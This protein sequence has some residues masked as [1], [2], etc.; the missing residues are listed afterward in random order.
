MAFTTVTLNPG[1]GGANVAFWQDGVNAV[2]QYVAIES[3]VPGNDPQ[4][5]GS[6]NPLPVTF[7]S[8]QPVVGN[9]ASGASD[10]GNGVK[11]A[12]VYNSTPSTFVN[13]QRTDLQTDANG[14]IKVNVAAGGGSGGTASNF[15]I[16]FPAQGTAM[17][18]TN[19][20]T[21]QPLNVDGSGNLKVNVTAGS[22]QAITD[23]NS[24]FTSGSTQALPGAFAY[25]D[26]ASALTSGNMG[27]ARVTANRQQRMVL[28]S[29]TS[30]GLTFFNL[31]A[32]AT[33]AKSAVKA[34]AGQLYFIH[35]VNV[36]ATPVYIKV[37]NAA[38]GSVTLGTT[39]ADYQF[40]VPGNTAGAGFTVSIVQG[41]AN[42]T[43][44]TIA[45]TGGIG[46][47]DNTSITA[48]SVNV[49]MGYA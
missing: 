39:A 3:Q 7:S 24:T 17:G 13:G 23:N 44:I 5:V 22:V 36:L 31:I 2:H 29:A 20:T 11:V 38:S 21:M 49:M 25:N 18:A 30:G 27:I 40:A 6:A 4:P 48:T 9:V 1:S 10:S 34:S 41:I 26:S 47:T 14:F 46:L 43:A 37:F 32:P 19:G 15:G 42:G 16:S 28:D 45:V 35:A 12:G 33:P 8:A